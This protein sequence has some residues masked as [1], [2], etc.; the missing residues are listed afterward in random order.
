MTLLR[1]LLLSAVLAMT[2]AVPAFAVDATKP[3]PGCGPQVTDE[4]GDEETYSGQFDA[5]SL[6]LVGGFLTFDQASSEMRVNLVIK[7]LSMNL[8]PDTTAARWRLL[9]GTPQGQ[10][11]VGAALNPPGTEVVYQTGTVNADGGFTP[12]SGP[13]QGKWFAGPNGVVQVVIPKTFFGGKPGDT[14]TSPKFATYYGVGGV[15]TTQVGEADVADTLDDYTVGPCK[16]ADNGGSGGGGGGGTPIPTPSRPGGTPATPV[17][18]T[19]TL[20]GAPAKTVVAGTTLTLK[21]SVNPAGASNVELFATPA[22]GVPISAGSATPD[23]AGVATFQVKPQ[24]NTTY[25]AKVGGSSSLPVGVTVSSKVTLKAASKGKGKKRTVTLTGAVAPDANG[26]VTVERQAGKAWKKVGSA[27]VV[28]GKFKLVLKGDKA[29]KGSYRARFATPGGI[30][31][32]GVSAP[33]KAR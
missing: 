20:T 5:P 3:S 22:G 10:K 15:G 19:V 32:P 2:A 7:D 4:P 1:A 29:A 13:V 31:K 18:P 33:A 16:P 30:R 8:P 23:A 21:A 11:Y 12:D 14:I 9:F 27:K 26:S 28:K 17:T 24:V 25:Q 6:D